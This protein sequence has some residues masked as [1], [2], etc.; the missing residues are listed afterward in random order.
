MVNLSVLGISVVVVAAVLFARQVSRLSVSRPS[1]HRDPFVG[2][3]AFA[4]LGLV[5]AVATAYFA[6]TPPEQRPDFERTMFVL[7]PA[8]GAWLGWLL[9]RAAP[10]QPE[11]LVANLPEQPSFDRSAT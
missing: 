6:P 5:A 8:A 4:A 1:H 11:R 9:V 3:I 7:L 2:M 10:Q